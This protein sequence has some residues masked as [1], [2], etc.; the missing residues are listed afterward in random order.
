MNTIKILSL[1]FILSICS[2]GCIDDLINPDNNGCDIERSETIANGGGFSGRLSPRNHVFE[3]DVTEKGTI[4]TISVTTNSDQRRTTMHLSK[5]SGFSTIS[6]TGSGSASSSETIQNFEIEETGKHTLVVT[7]DEGDETNYQLSICADNIENFTKL[8]GKIDTK[9][10]AWEPTGGGY[11]NHFSARNHEYTFSVTEENTYIDVTLATQSDQV[12][13]ILH[14][15][16]GQGTNLSNIKSSGSASTYEVI[17]ELL[18]QD[19]GNYTLVVAANDEIGGDYELNLFSLEGKVT[20]LVLVE[21]LV[22]EKTGAWL[23]NGGG[24]GSPESPLNHTWEF[25]TL[26]EDAV[27]DVV[28]ATRSDQIRGVIYLFKGSGNNRSQIYHSGSA[29]SLE[30]VTGAIL[31]EIGTYQIV[32]ATNTDSSGD[33]DLSVYATQGE[34]TEPVKR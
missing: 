19:I 17:S 29:S 4:D 24:Y 7:T 3:F 27:I 15:F 14:V 8:T 16:K 22:H 9:T 21:K 2:T 20:D 13:G 26:R 28:L 23:P 11:A 1:L 12:R 30:A 6:L 32:V 31:S 5:G 18:I 25:Q 34:I 10:N 33:Y